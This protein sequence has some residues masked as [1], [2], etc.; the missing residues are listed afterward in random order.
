MAEPSTLQPPA[1][2]PTPSVPSPQLFSLAGKTA[3]VTGGTRGIGAA[4]AIALAQA[5][6]SI[7]LLQRDITK[8]STQTHILQLGGGIKCEIVEADLSDLK[9]TREAFKKGV[10]VMGG[11]IDMLINCAGIQ[12]R[13]PAVDFSDEDWND[14]SPNFLIAPKS[15]SPGI[16]DR[17]YKPTSA[18]VGSSVKR[19]ES[20][21]FLGGA[22]RSSTSPRSSPSK[23]G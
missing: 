18:H 4:C 21:W 19:L 11:Q 23:E 14:V 10:E 2:A 6:A 8:T 5:G 9:A 7:C 12:R 15:N 16:T 13:A 3:L 20:I 17:S 1:G 22:A